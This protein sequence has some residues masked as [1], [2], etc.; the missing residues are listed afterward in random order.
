[1]TTKQKQ[2][3]ERTMGNNFPPEKGQKWIYKTV[4]RT[5]NEW[6]NTDYARKIGKLITHISRL[7]KEKVFWAKNNLDKIE[8]VPKEK[9]YTTNALAVDSINNLGRNWRKRSTPVYCTKR[10]IQRNTRK[11]FAL[12]WYQGKW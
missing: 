10:S 1:M 8:E 6:K 7:S 2:I 3:K 4:P 11:K 5:T 9:V 12:M